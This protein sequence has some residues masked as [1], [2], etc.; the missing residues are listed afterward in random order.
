MRFYQVGDALEAAIG[1]RKARP[2]VRISFEAAGADSFIPDGDIIE[3]EMT[4]FREEAGGIVNRGTLVLA[5]DF[6]LYTPELHAGL[7]PGTPV[8]VWYS[9]AGAAESFLRFSMYADQSGFQAEA[10]G[11]G[12]R[13]CTVRLVDLS[14]RLRKQEMQD[15]WTGQET[16][17]HCVMCSKAEPSRSLVHVIAARAGLT[18]ADIDCGDLPFSIPYHEIRGSVWDELSEAA[19][20]YGAVLECGKEMPLSFAESPYDT[21]NAYED[22]DTCTLEADEM[23]HYR[24]FDSYERYAD[25]VRL[26][27]TKYTET[28]RTELWSYA[29]NPV[30]YDEAMDAWYPFLGTRAIERED[31]YGASYTARNAEGRICSVVYAEDVDGREAFEKAIETRDGK[32]L[33]VLRYDT[34]ASRTSAGVRVAAPA[35]GALVRKMA[36]HGKAV[37]AERNCSVYVRDEEGIKAHGTVS[38]DCTNRFLSSTPFGGKEQYRVFAERLLAERSV[39][40]H[41]FFVKTNK[42]LINAR[43]GASMSID[44]GSAGGGTVGTHIEE[45]TLRYR[46]DAAFETALWLE[47]R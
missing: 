46:K 42:A 24:R 8:H 37:I 34:E 16:A 47:T 9:F 29:D 15:D 12:R 25:A 11:D 4:S 27:F 45:V 31:D 10:T 39:L 2:F 18:A 30:W 22:R 23:T 32:R 41:S 26:R 33:S 43:A 44:P 19:R 20:A 14:A 7:G 17:V 28:G 1:D 35:G 21:T 36:I 13:I 40:R 3:C 5:D 6:G 38:L